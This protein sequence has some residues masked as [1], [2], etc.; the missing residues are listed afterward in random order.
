MFSFETKF[1]SVS[2]TEF[3]NKWSDDPNKTSGLLTHVVQTDFNSASDFLIN[4]TS[5]FPFPGLL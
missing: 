1:Y 2:F 3:K 5:Q 4:P